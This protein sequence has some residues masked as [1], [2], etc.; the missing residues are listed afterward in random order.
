M[1][2]IAAVVLTLGMVAAACG[3]STTEQGQSGGGDSGD[4]APPITAEPDAGTPQPGGKLAYGL[5]AETDGWD[6]STARWAASGYQVAGTI[7][8]RL[9]AMDENYEVQPYLLSSI[10]P[11]DDFTVWTLGVRPGVTFH[12]DT[13]VDA[14]A[15]VAN[16]AA[17]KASPLTGTALSDIDTIEA[18]A[19]GS[20]VIVTMKKSWSTYPLQLTAQIGH[21]AEPSTLGDKE[22][23]LRPIGSGPFTFG[24]WQSG[25][26]LEVNKNP[27]YW[28]DGL[29]YLDSIEFKVLTDNQ[30]RRA[31]LT[32]GGLDMA[33]FFDVDSINEF[34][35]DT[36]GDYRVIADPTGES[37]EA[38]ILLNTATPP[39]DN[40]DARR[41][42]A[43]A[44]DSPTVTAFVGDGLVPA[45]GPIAESSRWFVPDVG[46]LAYNPEEAKKLV[47]KVKAE[48]GSFTFELTGVP[49]VETQR[50]SQYLQS[51][52]SEVGMD[53]KLADTEQTT[54]ISRAVLGQF[55]A[56]TWRQFGAAHPDGE[57]VWT[58]GG[59]AKPVNELSLNM[60]RNNDPE[61]DA[62]LDAARESDDFETQK[63]Q[64]AIW[65][66]RLSETVPYIWI[67][68]V[69][70]VV[71][72]TTNV[73]D[74][75]K[76]Q[77]PNGGNQ[78]AI[79][80]VVHPMSQIWI[81]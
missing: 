62:A 58:Y 46:Q 33:E 57:Y 45:S 43:M 67:Y 1:A 50:F 2:A 77:L 38:M 35:A 74:I 23:N 16:L 54:L 70:P 5:V 13:P 34:N 47:E 56:L 63:A 21:I 18:N 75:T 49:V 27:N 11:N 26:K 65:Q 72:A 20:A 7:Y 52:W 60:A 79:S 73:H 9:G 66:K 59:N 41:A 81:S 22:A 53:V 71:V 31:A 44:T 30:A 80:S 8:D 37:E 17:F 14:A 78:L 68:H 6:P 24:D 64:Y 76:A 51:A 48:T 29:P 10:E 25:S 42:L 28:R 3:S 69:E 15:I 61:L 39:F 4:G 55:Q 40:L 19:D 32:S 12:N 36:S